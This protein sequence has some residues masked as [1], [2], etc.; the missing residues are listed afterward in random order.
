MGVGHGQGQDGHQNYQAVSGFGNQDRIDFFREEVEAG[1]TKMI[2]G[3]VLS[4]VAAAAIGFS[5]YQLLTRPALERP[6]QRENF[7]S[8][9]LFP[10]AGGGGLLVRAHF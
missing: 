9:A 6:P 8:A 7:Q 10:V 1:R 3:G 5:L 4:G 2:V